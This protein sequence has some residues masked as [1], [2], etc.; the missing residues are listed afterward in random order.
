MKTNN[1]DMDRLS[2]LPDDILVPIL[3]VLTLKEAGRTSVLSKRWRYLWTFTTGSLDFD[4]EGLVKTSLK[5]RRRSFVKMVNRVLKLHQ[6]HTIDEFRVCFDVNGMKFKSEID[7]WI[8]FSLR[9]KVK[10]LLLEFKPIMSDF[11]Y[12]LTMKF[13]HESSSNLLCGDFLT[14][15]CLSNVEVTGEVLD[16]VLSNC[17]SIEVL[18]VEGSQSLVELKPSCPLLKLKHLMIL[19]CS[20]LRIVEIS[21]INLVSFKYCGKATRMLL[22]DVP[23]LVEM[24]LSFQYSDILVDNRILPSHYFPQ[25]ETV[26]NNLLEIS[27]SFQ[28]SDMLDNIILNSCYFSLLETLVLELP[29]MVDSLHFC[30]SLLNASPVLHKFTIKL[31]GLEDVPAEGNRTVTRD[32]Y[33]HQCLKVFELIGFVG[34]AIDME[35]AMYI[36]NNVV[37]LEKIIIDTR[38]LD[39]EEMLLD[40]RDHEK[41]LAAIACARQLE[42]RLPLG[43]ELVILS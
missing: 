19:C 36:I 29:T 4:G 14:D 28:Y 42:T 17:P 37:S 3:S 9:K 25:L 22:G 6:G 11:R 1:F 41:N 2:E 13:L 12:T 23:N 43:V 8:S 32:E 34:C 40:S 24:Y 16:C 31:I 5:F 18:R 21:A 10:R 20:F 27:L 15:L 35:L 38:S 39:V 30:S 33:P 26:I 7:N